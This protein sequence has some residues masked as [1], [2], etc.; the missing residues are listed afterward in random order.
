MHRIIKDLLRSVG[1]DDPRKTSHRFKHT[2]ATKA[3]RVT[4]NIRRVQAMMDHESVETT[5]IY[6][7]N[8]DRLKN[9]TEDAIGQ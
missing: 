4:K 2:T 9:A 3:L 8:L 6:A 1:I 5:M 7:H